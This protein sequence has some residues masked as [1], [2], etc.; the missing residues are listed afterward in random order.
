[1]AETCLRAD[2]TGEKEEVSV[3]R[4]ERQQEKKMETERIRDMHEGD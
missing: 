1:M 3:R 4:K 2:S